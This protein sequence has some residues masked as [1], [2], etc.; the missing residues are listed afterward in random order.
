MNKTLSLL[1][2]ITTFCI[3]QQTGAR[4][5]VITH[6]DFYDAIQPLVQWKHNKGV[7]TKTVKLSEI[8]SSS[9]QIKSYV[10]NA[11]NTWDITPE[12]L[13]LVGA[14]NYLPLPTIS[15]VYTDN[16]YTNM[17]GD[18]YNEILPGRL[19][20]RSANEAETVVNKMLLYE[21]NPDL[22]DS[23]WFIN[24]CLIVRDDYDTYDDSIY[25]DDVKY[26]RSLM[27]SYEYNDIDTLSRAA[28]NNANDVVQAVNNGRAFVLYRGQGVN[29]WWSPFDV[30]PD[31]TSNGNK[32]PIVLSI[33]CRTI[34]TGSTPATAER[35]FLTGSPTLPR[36][37]AAY[38]AATT[39][40][41][42]GAYLRSAV[43]KGFFRTL[44]SERQR[45]FG[46]ACEGG[47]AAVY[48]MY[49]SSSEF[50]G[51]M[52]IG[53]PEMNIWTAIPKTTE[54]FHDSTIYV[55]DESLSVLVHF[56]STPLES[57]LVCI[58]IDTIFH[59]YGY[60]ATDGKIILQLDNLIPGSLT[61]TVTARN[62]IPYQ[63]QIMVTDTSAFLI[64]TDLVVSDSLSNN[65]GLVENGETIL[66]RSLIT[67]IGASTAHSVLG[68]LTTQDTMVSIIDSIV[69][70]GHINPMDSSLGSSPYT[71]TISPFCPGG[72]DLDFNLLLVDGNNNSWN[73]NFSLNVQSLGGGTGPDPYGYYMYDNTDTSSG[74]APVFD[75]FDIGP[76]SGPGQLVS[77]ITNEDADT[78]TYP[79]P[80]TFKYYNI[81][82]SSIG[83][84][85]NGFLEL[86]HST[87]RFGDNTSLPAPSGPRRT[88]AA[89]WDDLDPSLYGDIYCYN[90]TINNRWILQFEECAH[91]GSSS[92]RE[93]FQIIIFDP[94]YYQTPTGDGECIYQYL[95]VADATSNT[96]GIEDETETRGL[97]YVFNSIY[98]PNA[99][100]IVANRAILV[101]T[102][103]PDGSINTPWLHILDYT[104]S[105][106]AGGNNN[107]IVEPDET[108]DV[109]MT[110]D[111]R[112]DTTASAVNGILR[113]TDSDATILD[114]IFVY[115][116][117][118]VG[119]TANNYSAPYRVHISTA[120]AD[121]TIGLSLHFEANSG[122]YYKDDY[123]T[124]YIYGYPGIEE[125]KPLNHKNSFSFEIF[126]NPSKGMLSIIFQAPESQF[127]NTIKIYDVSGR[128]VK[129]LSYHTLDAL[130][131][132]LISW[133]GYDE[134]GRRVA[135]GVYFVSCETMNEK[136]VKKAVIIK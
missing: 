124:S 92:T 57:A 73:A 16:Y 45:T 26:A 103:P 121:S 58:T 6:D 120:P 2:I 14:P 12:F 23:L 46:Q 87:H 117:M 28:G 110:I 31:A 132:T 64:Y 134:N 108:I 71:I 48:D 86:D 93:T 38:F 105:D 13:L 122:T 94:Q 70:F 82:Y 85:S 69:S 4:Y 111:N 104:L 115:G 30:N 52:T 34:G 127:Q 62:V 102:K 99:Q 19:T 55:N 112:G 51:F 79:L 25:W 97:R 136:K 54:V 17:D 59:K 106:S 65:N 66:L 10:E 129:D 80:F 123:F 107:G 78:V 74:H 20:V 95:Y 15:G 44:F 133:D 61:L 27:Q 24:A 128:L 96:V 81:D 11:Y 100:P 125:Y 114:S 42:S 126:P 101:T 8:G 119:A 75:W 41:T 39:V 60:T 77:E 67:N 9:A 109:Y 7:K 36:G 89:F 90:D 83:M 72:H 5:L 113:S 32:L 88:L 18:I 130:H 131:P 84:C 116:D 47:R 40:V 76:P 98:D 3:A 43:C 29:N 118:T 37:G 68:I 135:N 1:T 49:G 53:D 22:T 50:N 33:T 21:K 35:W 63:A 91:Y 56:N